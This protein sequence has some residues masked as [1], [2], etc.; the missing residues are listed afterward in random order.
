[1]STFA[2]MGLLSTSTLF[3]L[4]ELSLLILLET[5]IDGYATNKL[6]CCIG[7]IFG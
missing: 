6:F 5:T 1:M 3:E 7:R 2:V 4:C